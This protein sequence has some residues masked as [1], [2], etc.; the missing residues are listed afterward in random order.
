MWWSLREIEAAGRRC[1]AAPFTSARPDR[2]MPRCPRLVWRSGGAA[3]CRKGMPLTSLLAPIHQM[4]RPVI[5]PLSCKAVSTKRVNDPLTIGEHT[6]VA[7]RHGTTALSHH[8]GM[9]PCRYGAMNP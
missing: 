2:D 9:T 7:S 8:G 1:Y 4:L 5:K 3:S 6:M